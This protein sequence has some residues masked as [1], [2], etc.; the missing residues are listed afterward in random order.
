[1]KARL[2]HNTKS[3]LSFSPASLQTLDFTNRNF[4]MAITKNLNFTQR[5]LKAFAKVFRAARV[6]ARMT[7]L[8]V[9]TKAFGYEVSHCKVSRVER[10]VMSKVDAHCLESLASVL[11]VPAGVLHKIDP[12]F[13]DRAV[14]VRE[15]TRR[16]FWSPS[17]RRVDPSRC[18]A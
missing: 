3:D 15:A 1:M 6:N 16:G 11:A 10:A 12:M 5:Q 17:A 14:V 9:A 8:Q 18:T 7:Q 13:K 2:R 4:V